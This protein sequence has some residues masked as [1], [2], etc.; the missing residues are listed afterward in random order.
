MGLGLNYKQKIQIGEH[1]IVL[2]PLPKDRNEILFIDNKPDEAYWN[3]DDSDGRI[4]GTRRSVY[5][6]L[7]SQFIPFKTLVD[8]SHTKYD[9]KTGELIQ[10]SIDDTKIV[11]SIYKDVNKKR[12]NGVFMRNG[13]DIEYLSPSHWFTL[14][15]CKMFGNTK[16][17]GYGFFYKYQRDIFYLLD[18]MW[19]EW[20]LGLYISKAKK[21]GITQI[22]DGGYCLDKATSMF[23]WMIGFMS[24]NE[25]AAVENN[26]KLFLYAFDNLPL[27][28]RPKVGFKAP[29][30]GNIEFSELTKSKVLKTSTDEVL[31]TRVF[32]VPTSEHS[33]DS[34][35]MNLEHFDEYPKYYQDSKKN[36]KEI[37]NGNKAGAKDQDF[38]R[39][40]VIISSY[41]PEEDDEGSEA[42]AE[43][44][45]ESK[46]VT[47]K[48]GKTQSE[49]ICYH[50][51][52][53]KSLKS[54]IGKSGDCDEKKAMEIIG[55]NRERV[56]KD[57]K[58]LM[59][60]I[61]QNPNNEEEAFGSNTQTSVFDPIRVAEID[62]ANE[63]ER[64][65]SPHNPYIDGKLEWEN[66]KWERGL[67]NR[68]PRG[69]FGK[70][71]FV[72]L[73]REEL[74]KAEQGRLRIYFDL[75]DNQKCAVLRNGKDE[76][77]CVIPPQF[78]SH[79]AG[80]DPTSHAAASEVIEGSKNAYV[81]KSRKNPSLDS[82]LRHTGRPASGIITHVYFYRP[83]LPDEA[84][85]D[86]VKLIIYTGCLITVE[87]NV[88]EFATRL[89]AEGLGRFM[90]VKDKAGNYVIWSRWMGLA[91]EEDKQYHLI[92]T[93]SNSQDSKVL[94]EIFVR[95]IKMFIQRPEDGEKD[96]GMTIKDERVIKQLKKFD[97]MDTKIFD[98]IMAW[99]YA[100]FTDE[101]Y[102]NLLLEGTE[103]YYAGANIGALLAALER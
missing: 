45:R 84:Y 37:L 14:E 60:E 59:A 1:E 43:V 46:L 89:L 77:D 65:L 75:N 11:R 56:K 73:T 100:E 5:D 66:Q 95:L 24:R 4:I 26:M 33:F 35:F 54:C 29:K 6:P 97:P 47:K 83:E 52:A 58:A 64:L 36:P 17:N 72:P 85:E 70:V 38:F 23:Q 19:K 51:P 34:H 76:F 50:I 57:R 20:C 79:V 48:Y 40:R 94:L 3:I 15:H 78:Y 88:P 39:G 22:I 32:C 86:L 18:Y 87:A 80:A 49:L 96:Y 81:V 10:L 62:L 68:R 98:L 25:D 55:Q 2:P 21:T 90:M 91:H 42:A 82:A 31:N 8:C 53:F 61:R 41:P 27:A 92:R 69:E 16:N 7:F 63:E 102:S 74:E 67:K 13:N 93:T 28:L 44:Y 9:D 30:G 101:M 12:K 71:K 99:G 103:D